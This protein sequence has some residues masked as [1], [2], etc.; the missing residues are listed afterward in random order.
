MLDRRYSSV[1]I[2]DIKYYLHK[3]GHGSVDIVRP[4]DLTREANSAS[5]NE[6][7]VVVVICIEFVQTE[8]EC[9]LILLV[10]LLR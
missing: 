5:G 10:V 3:R 4:S 7:L 8:C 6:L 2:D 9:E 1:L